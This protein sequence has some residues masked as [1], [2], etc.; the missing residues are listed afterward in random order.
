[1]GALRGEFLCATKVLGTTLALETAMTPFAYAGAVALAVPFVFVYRS[2]R[3]SN[4][5]PFN[6]PSFVFRILYAL[7]NSSLGQTIHN[8]MLTSHQNSSAGIPH[9]VA[10]TAVD[11]FES[12]FSV[13]Y[14]PFLEDNYAYFIVDRA[15]GKTA[16]VDPADPES[17]M[18]AF[19]HLK[20][21]MNRTDLTLTMICC[22]HKHMDHAGGNLAL[23]SKF[24]NVQVVAGTKETVLGQTVAAQHE[25]TV[26]LGTTPVLVLETPCHTIGHVVFFAGDTTHGGAL[27][28][29]DT[30]FLG[31]CGKFF[32]G[33]APLMYNTLYKVILG[34]KL[35]L[36]T[37]K[38]YCGHEY[39]Q[40]S[41]EFGIQVEPD[42]VALRRKLETVIGQRK[43]R[44]PTVPSVLKD[45]LEYNVFLRCCGPSSAT[46][47]SRL[48]LAPAADNGS[49]EDHGVAIE[50]VGLLRRW[51]DSKKS[52]PPT[53][54]NI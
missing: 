20:E 7:Y 17:V 33:N 52:T 42:N 32:E 4:L 6:E 35:P 50:A 14:V 10:C 13:S 38:V 29:G 40:S 8:Y 51:K 22:T 41:L 18:T 53:A 54:A 15:T 44:L 47:R 46:I 43:E 19:D 36:A 27:F 45:E 37:T 1:M 2:L 25:Q 48:S 11:E 28:S 39:S 3:A 30:L 9:T 23:K 31:G 5:H 34:G 49:M 21:I 26:Y 24:K 12:G 16:V